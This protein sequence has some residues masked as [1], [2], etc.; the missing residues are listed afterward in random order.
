MKIITLIAVAALSAHA[1]YV[2]PPPASGS[3][4]GSGSGTATAITTSTVSGLPASCS[5]G[6]A[7]FAT[8]ATVSSGGYYVYYCVSGAWQQFGYVA[9]SSGALAANC[10]TSPCTMDVTSAVPLKSTANVWTGANDFSTAAKT[11]PF[12]IGASD[13]A[14][15]DPATREFFVNTASNSLKSCNATNTW[16]A[17]G[18]GGGSTYDP[19]AATVAVIDEEWIGGGS[20]S[21]YWG[22]GWVWADTNAAQSFS[23]IEGVANHPGIAQISTST[24]ADIT[25][26]LKPSG[27]VNQVAGMNSVTFT[28]TCIIKTDSSVSGLTKL[29]CGFGNTHQYGINALYE[30]GAS[31]NWRL[32]VCSSFDCDTPID[33][34]VAVATSTWYTI[35]LD[36]TTAG[37]IGLSVNGSARVTKSTHVPS[38]SMPIV[39]LGSITA[40]TA[41]TFQSDAYKLKINVTR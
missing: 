32:N 25:T 17:V 30:P 20:S 38:V 37:T 18:G 7:R 24:S 5:A 23:Y 3:G 10:S 16:T 22:Q 8:D 36:S 1:Q 35:V 9:G 41:R 39:G 2:F 26:T 28:N 6:D 11:A 4:G 15:C 27:G 34:G 33:T 13:P 40:A 29:W 19:T 14:T 12:R 21:G 31:A